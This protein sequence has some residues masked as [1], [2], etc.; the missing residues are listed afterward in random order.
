M[1]LLS[2]ELIDGNEKK[3]RSK[4]F[5][6]YDDFLRPESKALDSGWIET[7]PDIQNRINLVSERVVFSS[8]GDS[9]Y[10]P[11]LKKNFT[12]QTSDTLIWQFTMQWQCNDP[13]YDTFSLYFQLGSNM[14]DN[15]PWNNVAVNLRWGDRTVPG[16]TS[17]EMF[18][19]VSTVNCNFSGGD[20]VPEGKGLKVLNTSAQIKVI[21]YLASKRYSIQIDGKEYAK[22]IPYFKSDVMNVNQ[23]RVF[24]HNLN[25]IKFS[26]CTLDNIS[27]LKKAA[28]SYSSADELN[29][30]DYGVSW[31][32][33]EEE[34][35]TFK[36]ATNSY[37]KNTPTLNKYRTPLYQSIEKPVTV[38]VEHPPTIDIPVRF[39]DYHSDRRNPEFEQ[40]AVGSLLS[41]G[42]IAAKLDND[43]KPVVSGV[44]SQYN[45]NYYIRY[46]FRK[47]RTSD[48]TLLRMYKTTCEYLDFSPPTERLPSTVDIRIPTGP[49]YRLARD[50]FANIVIDSSLKFTH[51]GDGVYQFNSSDFFPLDNKGFGNEKTFTE[52]TGDKHNFSFTME[53]IHS[54]VKVPGQYLKFKGDDDV[55][56]FINDSLVLDIGGKHIALSDSFFV[57]N[58]SQLENNTA[59][60]MKLF[61]CE[62]HTYGSSMLITTNMTLSSP[63]SNKSRMWR[64]DYGNIY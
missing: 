7:E 23:M 26:G 28:D 21:I 18:G 12:A 63:P 47:T 33:L 14:T 30:G 11:L 49:K 15:A 5:I 20:C 56:I 64:R 51:I 19:Y 4:N 17:K 32:V 3:Y 9:L 8:N 44:T 27:L 37:I 41:K 60:S 53:M 39:Y 16:F 43:G 54:F 34:I 57:D 10:R 46:W 58:L 13:D 29:Y 59:Y 50:A 6:V 36:L 24:T 42:M 52:P 48:S 35:G 22:N 38:K 62:R 25:T 2:Q 45:L 31:D 1:T 40:P 55:W 61:Y